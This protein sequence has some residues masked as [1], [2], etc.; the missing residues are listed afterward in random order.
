MGLHVL[1]TSFCVIVAQPFHVGVLVVLFIPG[2]QYSGME[3]V[4]QPR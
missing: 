3:L 2:P 4:N 1:N